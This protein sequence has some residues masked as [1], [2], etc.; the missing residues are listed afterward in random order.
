MAREFFDEKN[1]TYIDFDVLMETREYIS[2]EGFHSFLNLHA[3]ELVQSKKDKD[4]TQIFI[5]TNRDAFE[6]LRKIRSSLA[7]EY[8][9][10]AYIIA[11]DQQLCEII[12]HQ[13]RS[14]GE[15]MRVGGLST[16]AVTKYGPEIIKALKTITSP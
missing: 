16:Q 10:P 12:K 14:L 15:L 4:Q 6:L 7:S 1:I 8:R 3:Q 11:K 9:V 13:P 2:L 5:E